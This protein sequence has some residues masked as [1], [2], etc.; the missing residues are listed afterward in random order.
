[1]IK[2]VLIVVASVVLAALVLDFLLRSRRSGKSDG[3][4]I[5]DLGD[6]FRELKTG[7]KPGAAPRIHPHEDDSDLP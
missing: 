6:A 5:R 1:M 2:T 4:M 3:V 7:I